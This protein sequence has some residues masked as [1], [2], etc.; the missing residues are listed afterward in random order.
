MKR[1]T[2]IERRKLKSNL[3]EKDQASDPLEVHLTQSHPLDT[4]VIP[5]TPPTEKNLD[6]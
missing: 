5:I 6:S 3:P 4:I 2:Q 1:T